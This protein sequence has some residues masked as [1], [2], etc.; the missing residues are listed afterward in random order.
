MTSRRILAAMAVMLLGAFA[1]ATAQTVPMAFNYQGIARD[2]EGSVVPNGTLT[3]R[4]SVIDATTSNVQYV[5]RHVASTNEFGLFTLQVGRGTAISGTMAG[6][7]WAGG[8]KNLKVEI[9]FGGGF[10]DLGSSPLLSVPYALVAGNSGPSQLGMDDLTDVVAPSPTAGSL[11]VYNGTNWV[12]M[13]LNATLP[14]PFADTISSTSLTPLF[15]LRQIGDGPVFRLQ[16]GNRNSASATLILENAGQGPSLLAINTN[17]VGSTARFF[18]Q[19]ANNA[20]PV[21]T[22]I[23]TGTGSAG[24]FEILNRNSDSAAVYARTNG[25]G[26]GVYG[27]ASGFGRAYGV[28]GEAMGECNPDIT[29]IRIEC[30][31]G[32][33][34]RSR[35]GPGVFGYNVDLGPGVQAFSQSGKIFLGLGPTANLGFNDMRF[36][37]D[38]DGRTYTESDVNAAQ[39]VTAGGEAYASIVTSGDTGLAAGDIAAVDV[40]GAIV[41]GI[42]TIETHVIG[43]VV[44]DPGFLAGNELDEDGD[45]TNGTQAVYVATTGIVTINVNT[46]NGPIAPG[47]MLMSSSVAGEATW[48]GPEPAAGTVVAKALEAYTGANPGTIRAVVMLR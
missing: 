33:Y 29:G 1:N 26:P 8:A 38:N 19:S 6:V 40:N 46:E 43:V 4:L 13:P 25:T 14:L 44:D 37:I 39:S 10:I 41:Q 48:A 27:E 30:P 31:T 11:L 2:A 5:E 22:A 28:Y 7:N 32:V 18:T 24:Y 9:D 20:D 17:A 42:D 34:G 21:I 15:D 36:F 47:D 16:Q 12:S 45:P 23:T 35:R 3:L